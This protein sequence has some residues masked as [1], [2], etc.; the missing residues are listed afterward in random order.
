MLLKD[1]V[2]SFL[3]KQIQCPNDWLVELSFLR[4]TIEEGSL[5]EP[6]KGKSP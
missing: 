3:S 4:L 5:I 6:G 1:C 2:K